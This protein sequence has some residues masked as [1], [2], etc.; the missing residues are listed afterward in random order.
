MKVLR[1]QEASLESSTSFYT[2]SRSFLNRGVR[3][4]KI[5]TPKTVKIHENVK[6]KENL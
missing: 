2:G 6:I 4:S 5:H 1:G 3:A